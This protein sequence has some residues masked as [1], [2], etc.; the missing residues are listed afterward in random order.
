[1]SSQRK[2]KAVHGHEPG[3]KRDRKRPPRKRVV[4]AGEAV[5]QM[6]DAPLTNPDRVSLSD[7]VEVIMI[8]DK[9]IE[10]CDAYRESMETAK[11]NYRVKVEAPDTP[12]QRMQV[13]EPLNEDEKRMRQRTIQAYQK[14]KRRDKKRQKRKLEDKRPIPQLPVESV[15]AGDDFTKRQPDIGF[16]GDVSAAEIQ[17]DDSG[18]SLAPAGGE[19]SSGAGD[20]KTQADEIKSNLPLMLQSYYVQNNKRA[21]PSAA[22]PYVPAM[23]APASAFLGEV[24]SSLMTRRNRVDRNLQSAC[25]ESSQFSFVTNILQHQRMCNIPIE[26]LPMFDTYFAQVCDRLREEE[27]AFLRQPIPQFGDRPCAKGKSCRGYFL[28]FGVERMAL[29]EYQKPEVVEEFRRTRKWPDKRGMCVM[30][31]RFEVCCT[32]TNIIAR[33]ASSETSTVEMEVVIK[34]SADGGVPNKPLSAA[35]FGNI[36]GEGQYSPWDVEMSRPMQYIGLVKPVVRHSTYMYR[37]VKRNGIWYCEQTIPKP[38]RHLRYGGGLDFD[39]SMS[40]TTMATREGQ[41]IPTVP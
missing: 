36:V 25:N 9:P 13:D 11:N 7:C 24:Q 18:Y 19:S 5:R 4:D 33:C 37:P 8:N 31:E 14:D 39:A 29:V 3:V 35:P 30:C 2:R 22:S 32:V 1:M 15:A 40:A 10:F 23:S 34:N 12:P 28:M 17:C 38:N 41:K 16:I 21:A 27:D 6:Y 20:S 26:R